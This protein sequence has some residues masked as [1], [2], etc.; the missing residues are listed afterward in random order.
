MASTE[1]K[2]ELVTLASACTLALALAHDDTV[3]KIADE[4]LK[5]HINELNRD[6]PGWDI[7]LALE[8]STRPANKDVIRRAGLTL[9]RDMNAIAGEFFGVE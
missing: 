6:Y 4:R 7:E 5:R 9:S 3:I 2:H 8:Q 1:R